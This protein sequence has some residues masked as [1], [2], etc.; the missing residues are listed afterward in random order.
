MRYQCL[1]MTLGS[2]E[3]GG[4]R[5]TVKKASKRFL[6]VYLI[7][8][9]ALLLSFIALHAYAQRESHRV[10]VFTWDAVHQTMPGEG[11]RTPCINMSIP[12]DKQWTDEDNH[13][14]TPAGAQYDFV[15]YYDPGRKIRDWSVQLTFQEQPVIDSSWNGTYEI[16]GNTIT[17][18]PDP[19]TDYMKFGVPFRFG[20]VMYGREMLQLQSY[21]LTGVLEV[22]MQSLPLYHVLT[23]LS[24]IW[25]VLFASTA[26]SY[27]RVRRLEAQRERDHL[28][29]SQSITTFTNFI[30]AKDPYT[31][32]HSLRVAAYSEELARRLGYEGDALKD[33]YYEALLHDAG[34]IGIPD[35]ILRKPGRLTREE[36]ETIK[37]HTTI[38]SEILKNFTAIPEI[39]DGA[40]YHHER[41]DGKGYPEGLSAT[42]IPRNARI[43][44]VADSYDAMSSHRSYR[45]PIPEEKIL[46]ELRDNSGSQFDPDIVP[47]MLDMIG[48]G[49]TKKV[50]EQYGAETAMP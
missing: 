28:M 15:L 5:T 19:N 39:C 31:K 9:A 38:G 36:Y 42:Q 25:A 3:Q 30:D 11:S 29:I 45:A 13:A 21:V 48:D 10:Q 16:S 50:R 12:S 17:F 2:G 35:A 34:K 23:A 27:E 43:I 24:V 1:R 46:S 33:I 7:A 6:P 44:C 8:A 49:F 18:T 20:A 41:W 40:H 47:V 26:I 32:G 4:R 22:S 37:T 14:L